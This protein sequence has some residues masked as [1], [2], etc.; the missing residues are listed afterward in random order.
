VREVFAT[1]YSLWMYTMNRCISTASGLHYAPKSTIKK[2][3]AYAL[4]YWAAALFILQICVSAAHAQQDVVLSAPEQVILQPGEVARQ[5]PPKAL[6]GRLRVV[7]G[8]D[9]LIDGK[10]ERLSPGA[11][12]RGPNNMLVMTGAMVGQEYLVNFVRETY[13]NVH[14]VWILTPEEAKKKLKTNT[15]ERNYLFSSEDQPK[16]DDGKTPFNQ[17]PKFKN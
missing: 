16:V 9:I 10:P 15:P 14:Q 1:T 5:F 4:F 13:G 8:A 12:I 7:Q 3:A 2:V 11:R 17:L 6:R